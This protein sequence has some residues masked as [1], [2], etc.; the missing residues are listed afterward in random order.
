[1]K[2]IEK[3]INSL[4]TVLLI[5]WIA[6][7]VVFFYTI[8]SIEFHNVAVDALKEINSIKQEASK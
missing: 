5:V 6:S 4:L 1:M 7:W 3:H 2:F 8:T